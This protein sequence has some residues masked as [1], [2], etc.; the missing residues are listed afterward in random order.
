MTE[1]KK[2]TTAFIISLIAG[3]FIIL[4][5]GA[6]SMFSSWMGNNGRVY[7]MMSGYGGYSGMMSGY[8]AWGEMMGPGFG[9]MG[10]LS[11][12]SGYIGVLGIIFGAIVIS[13]AFMLNSKPQ[14][15]TIWGT[16]IIVFAALSI[17]SSA[18]GGFGVGLILGIIGGILAMTWKLPATQAR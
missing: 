18:M 7:G 1:T 16:L 9:M 15:H 13:S 10:G 5:G 3:I 6:M 11:Y 12:G 17:F 8:R 2:P 14:E 4:G